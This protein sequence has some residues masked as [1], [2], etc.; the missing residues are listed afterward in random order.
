MITFSITHS[1]PTSRTTSPSLRNR[2]R[3]DAS[4]QDTLT[5]T[6]F[7]KGI[8][9][10]YNDLDIDQLKL[11]RQNGAAMQRTRQHRAGM[12]YVTFILFFVFAYAT[13]APGTVWSSRW[14]RVITP[15]RGPAHKW[16]R[17]GM[18]HQRHGAPVTPAKAGGGPPP[19]WIGMV[20]VGAET[21]E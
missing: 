6:R 15:G 16:V 8:S 9:D 7:D 19:R 5:G 21:P 14:A 13:A 17:H 18:R 11:R 3:S 1:T 12:R 20:C 4:T 2:S 10:Y